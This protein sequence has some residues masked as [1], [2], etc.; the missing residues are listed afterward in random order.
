[1]RI[2]RA[3]RGGTVLAVMSFGVAAAAAVIGWCWPSRSAAHRNRPADAPLPEWAVALDEEVA[4]LRSEVAS[5]RAL[6]RAL[7]RTERACPQCVSTV[8][9]PSAAE[10]PVTDPAVAA[11]PA[12]AD[13]YAAFE[14]LQ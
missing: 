2:S 4:A 7:P 12:M 14:A 13:A 8:A 9:P 3:G 5:L 10:P 11:A 1:M 6:Q